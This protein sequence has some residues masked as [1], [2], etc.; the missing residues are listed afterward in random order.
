VR[1]L[2]EVAVENDINYIFG[3]RT[4]KN[5]YALL[6]NG[7]DMKNIIKYSI[8]KGADV[9]SINELKRKIAYKDTS[10]FQKW[11]DLFTKMY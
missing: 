7:M 1:A 10:K 3:T 8:I 9:D 5:S 6:M 11:Y 2:R 4:L